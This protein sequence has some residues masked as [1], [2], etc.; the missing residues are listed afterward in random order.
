MDRRARLGSLEREANE[1][2]TNEVS[3]ADNS[4]MARDS[5]D[6]EPTESGSSAS[7]EQVTDLG[8]PQS[9]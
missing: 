3:D 8:Y 9:A 5:E 2:F 6:Y 7:H 4:G 1:D